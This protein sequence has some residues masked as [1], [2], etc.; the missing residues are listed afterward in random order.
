MKRRVFVWG[1]FISIIGLIFVLSSLKITG[2]VISQSSNIRNSVFGLLGIVLFIGGIL[3][4][5]LNMG[6]GLEV[7]IKIIGTP[8]GS[9]KN[10]END[11][12]LEEDDGKVVRRTKFADF[13]REAK[14]YAEG[15]F[16][17]YRERYSKGL[18]AIANN[19]QDKRSLIARAFLDALGEKAPEKSE[20]LSKDGSLR[21]ALKRKYILSEGSEEV[22]LFDTD[23]SHFMEEN[24]YKF[25]E[26]YFDG[27]KVQIGDVALEEMRRPQ[28]IRG[29]VGERHLVDEHIRNYIMHFSKKGDAVL[30][31]D[32]IVKEEQKAGVNTQEAE[33]IK[34]EIY[35][36]WLQ[37]KNGRQAKDYVRKNW[38]NTADAQHLYYGLIRGDKETVVLSDDK[39][40]YEV[41]RH[42]REHGIE[43]AG[44]KIKSPKLY[45]LSTNEVF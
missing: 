34:R 3:M 6:G 7:K 20:I 39:G 35:E 23:F 15:G 40:F 17:D 22:V 10:H 36:V 28:M 42:F 9:L 19:P 16:N 37:T 43:I 31:K 44:K 32:E 13:R 2:F 4:I 38:I 12:I 14:E 8:K 25:K 29:Q 11:W 24:R 45:V 1:V 26:G 30:S 5:T 41:A 27:Y 21:E 33:R 18:H